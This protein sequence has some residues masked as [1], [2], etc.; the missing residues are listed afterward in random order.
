M[1]VQHRSEQQM[2]LFVFVRMEILKILKMS[3]F[4]G[5]SRFQ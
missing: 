2:L 1:F 4:P 5:N 3:A